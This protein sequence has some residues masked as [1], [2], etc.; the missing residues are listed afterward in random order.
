M[1]SLSGRDPRRYGLVLGRFQPL[2]NGHIEYLEAA[3]KLADQL[4]VGI[5]SP[6]N[7]KLV[8]DSADPNRSQSES[9]PFSYFD[10]Y[11]MINA[12]LAAAGWDHDDFAVVPAP[13]NEPD[14][15]LPF[16][17][18]TAATTVFITVYDD[19]GDRKA[20]LMRGLGYQVEILWRRHKNSRLTSGTQ[21]R[22]ALRTGG[23]WQD[24]V[25]PAVARYLDESGW[26]AL[27]RGRPSP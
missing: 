18:P 9:N 5:T 4:V 2:H 8:H 11:Q 10:R 7:D 23:N 25:P 15:M 13:I 6:S 14:E 20:E 27:L 1:T 21:L 26:T 16:M 3:R 22:A 24:F 12:T 17:P 19:W